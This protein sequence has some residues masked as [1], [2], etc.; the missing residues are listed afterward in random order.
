MAIFLGIVYSFTKQLCEL[1]AKADEAKANKDHENAIEN[2]FSSANRNDSSH[3]VAKASENEQCPD[4]AE[5]Q[6][7][8]VFKFHNVN[9][10]VLVSLKVKFIWFLGFTFQL[11]DTAWRR[12]RPKRHRAAG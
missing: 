12:L 5:N 3:R 8:E 4:D 9:G 1:L 10:S 11:Q 2:R 7:C 6:S